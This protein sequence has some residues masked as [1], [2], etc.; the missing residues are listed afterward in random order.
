MTN[1]IGNYE[2]KNLPARSGPGEGGKTPPLSEV[3]GKDYFW[4]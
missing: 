3:H 2:L 1:T 4:T